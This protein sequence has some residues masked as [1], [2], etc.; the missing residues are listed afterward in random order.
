MEEQEKNTKPPAS[1]GSNVT[2]VTVLSIFLPGLGQLVNGDVGKGLG[3]M[4][5]TFV[6][7]AL[8]APLAL[9]LCIWSALDAYGRVNK[10]NEIIR[11]DAIRAADII[12]MQISSAEFATQIDKISMLGASG[13]LSPD[14]LAERKQKVIGQLKQKRVI[15]SSE[16]FLTALIPLMQSETLTKDELTQIKSL[17]LS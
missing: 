1:S 2:G 14:E 12:S 5:A 16:D 11:G 8:F 13:M 15:G 17:V 3:M 4:A 7:L 10:L 9:I 6:C